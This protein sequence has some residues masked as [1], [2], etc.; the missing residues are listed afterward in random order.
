MNIKDKKDF[1]EQIQSKI[2]TE[3]DNST[4][5]I[6]NFLELDNNYFDSIKEALNIFCEIKVT[7]NLSVKINSLLLSKANSYIL[8]NHQEKNFI[9]KEERDLIKIL[10]S[11]NVVV[12]KSEEKDKVIT[13]I[14][15]NESEKDFWYSIKFK[16]PK[17]IFGSINYYF[18]IKMTLNNLLQKIII[19]TYDELFKKNKVI[20]NI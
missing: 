8:L 5:Q 4:Y 15:I 12:E 6:I 11:I 16:T 20:N 2:K 14:K 9:L 19:L 10:E 17:E 18:I 3:I 7:N 13:Y 1:S